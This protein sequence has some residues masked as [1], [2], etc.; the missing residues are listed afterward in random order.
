VQEKKEKLSKSKNR[1]LKRWL[2]KGIK[3]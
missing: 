2:C 3:E 1:Y